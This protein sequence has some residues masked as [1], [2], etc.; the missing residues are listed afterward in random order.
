VRPFIFITI[1][2]RVTKWSEDMHSKYQVGLGLLLAAGLAIAEEQKPERTEIN[3]RLS[4]DQVENQQ[5]LD[6]A[7]NPLYESKLLAPVHD[8][9]DGVAEKTGLSMSIDYTAQFVGLSQ[10]DNPGQTANGDKNAGSGMVRFYGTWVLVDRDGPNSGRLNFKVEHRHSYTDRQVGGFPGIAQNGGYLGIFEPPFTD[11]GARLTILHWKQNFLDG[12]AT[13]ICGWIEVTDY[14]DVYLLA[15]P[16]TGFNNFVF[17]TGSAAMDLP[18]DAALGAGVGGML[19]K[20]MY[21]Q[22]GVVDA[23]SD[24]TDPLEGFN[25]FFSDNKYFSWAELGWTPGKD[26]IYFDNAHVTAWHKDSV[27]Q[28][29]A[30]GWGL[31]ASYQRWL[32]DQWLPFVRGGYTKDSG[33]LLETSLS[34]GIGYQPVPMRGVIGAG[35]NW[36]KPNGFGRDQYTGELFWR[37]QLTKELAITPSLQ[38]I[39]NPA[40][41][42]SQDNLVAFG[43]R[44]RV[45]L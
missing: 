18:N 20:N 36:G 31:N 21:A 30:S 24:P 34:A 37:Y 12:N 25:T 6:R 44:V 26:K 29:T 27:A 22:V 41:D 11:E 40:L 3:P 23:L 17:S 1:I 16:W 38:Y 2:G 39:Q 43:V 4:P 9:R 45:A 10:A 42:P 32:N 33:S 28:G 7:A 5:A 14:V 15:S 35:L 13:A 8:W 19:G